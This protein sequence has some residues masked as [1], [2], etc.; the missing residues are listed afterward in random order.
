MNRCVKRTLCTGLAALMLA[1]CMTGTTVYAETAKEKVDRLEAAL[2]Q[3]KASLA[4]LQK[5]KKNAETTKTKLQNQS[6]LL[7]EQL[8]ALLETITDAE[9]AV[10]NKE[11]EIAQKQAEIDSRW[12][13]FKQQMGAMQMMHD[14]GAVAMLASCDNLYELLT[15]S[16]T[17]QEVSEW[18]TQV[19]DE[20]KAQRETLNEEKAE[21]EAAKEELEN[22]K[23][24][25]ETKSGQ[26]AANIQAT[27]A[28]ITK[29]E[30]DAKAQQEVVS[31]A[32][33]EYDRAEAEWEAFVRQ[34]A[35]KAQQNQGGSS[36]FTSDMF[37]WPLPGYSTITTYFGETQNINGLIKA[38][39]KGIDVTTRGASPAILAAA[40]G[41]VTVARLSSSYGNYVMIY[42]GNG[43]AT[44]Y[45]HM[46][47][48]AVS[49]GQV[50]TAGQV[51]GYVGATGRATGPHL[52]LE[53]A[54]NGVPTDPAAAYPG[55]ELS[56]TGR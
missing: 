8:A 14:T 29:A 11:N 30:A 2:K 54:E 1:G 16:N 35:Q 37:I 10:G 32:Q 48:M 26:L 47:S 19:L 28:T 51:I 17:M 20:M 34:Q 25:L 3:E 46:S 49:E 40:G 55:L 21:L 27:D 9:E 38:G 6:A 44:L 23:A 43:Y 5:D 42:H 52:H 50:V 36:D 12:D 7:K 13:E 53:L 33:A 56:V 45:A 15:F 4:K 24:Q 18:N 22:R 31:M 41:T 39:H